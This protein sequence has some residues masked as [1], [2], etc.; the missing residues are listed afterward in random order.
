MDL[1][2]EAGRSDYA[3]QS[4]RGRASRCCTTVIGGSSSEAQ[5]GSS[6][7]RDG[8]VARDRPAELTVGADIGLTQNVVGGQHRAWRPRAPIRPSWPPARWA[9]RRS[10]R[11]RAVT[12]ATPHENKDVALAFLKEEV[13]QLE[14]FSAGAV[15]PSVSRA[16]SSSS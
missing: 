14:E 5:G 2:L 11:L 3:W 9:L 4:R 6:K 10:R 16:S 15:R 1:P 7:T 12:S 13:M 8:Q